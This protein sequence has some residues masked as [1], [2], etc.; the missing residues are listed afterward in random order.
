MHLTSEKPG[1]PLN[2]FLETL[3]HLLKG[4]IGA[5]LF[6]MGDAFKHAGLLLAP[7]LTVILGAICIYSNHLLLNSAHYIREKKKLI[8][9]PS[10]AETVELCFECGPKSFKRWT[11]AVRISVK[12]FIVITQLGFCCVYF[13]FVSSTAKKVLITHGI[14]YDVRFYM[15][16]M[17]VPVLLSCLIRTLKFLTPISLL[18]NVFLLSGIVL[19]LYLSSTDLPSISSRQAV[20]DWYS[21]PLFFG[22]TIYA[23][24]GISLVIPLQNEMRNQKKFSSPF[25]VLNIGMFIVMLILISMGF[26]GYLKYGE[27][28]RGS[29]SLNLPIDSPLTE[30]VQ[31]AVALGI[32]FS[33]AL[34]FYIAADLLWCEIDDSWGPFKKPICGEII[35]RSLLVLLTFVL[36]AVVPQLGLF[37]SLVGAVSSTALALVYPALCDIAIRTCPPEEGPLKTSDNILRL[38]LDVITLIVAFIGFILGTYYSLTAIIDAF[39]IPTTH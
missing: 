12:V 6:A 8:V 13:V 11:H 33:Y 17:F 18:S 1:K 3:I 26:I 14:D 19:T 32:V 2:G 4:N 9:D 24:E 29:V 27:E 25:G 21:L 16:I 34:Q 31:I 28:V 37:I 30:G 22:T 23:F 7:I 20:A 39:T 10:F 36:A 15:A 5:G 35:L 38:L